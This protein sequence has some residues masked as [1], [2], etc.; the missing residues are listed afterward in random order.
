MEE[1]SREGEWRECRGRVSGG[2][3]GG[4]VSGGSV[5]GG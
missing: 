5:E 3:V 4:R 2:S 1:V